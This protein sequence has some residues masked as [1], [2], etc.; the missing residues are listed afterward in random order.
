MSITDTLRDLKAKSGL[1][2]KALA[3]KSRIPF[4]TVH[5]YLI[6]TRRPSVENLFKLAKALGVGVEVFDPGRVKRAAD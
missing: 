2:E 1:T 5:G 6:G 3:R 4:G